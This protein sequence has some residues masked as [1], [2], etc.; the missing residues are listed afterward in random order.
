MFKNNT[1]AYCRET[2]RL[3][4]AT[5]PSAKRRAALAI[6]LN[7][8]AVMVTFAALVAFVY[9]RFWPDRASPLA[10]ALAYTVTQ[11]AIILA[12]LAWLSAAKFL[13]S[14]RTRRA[15]TVR[16]E[17]HELLADHATGIDRRRRLERLIAHHHRDVEGS[18]RDVLPLLSGSGRQ[19]IS[20]LANHLGL[21]RDWSRQARSRSAE[22]RFDGVV[23]LGLLTLEEVRET[24]L[25]ALGD[26]DPSV[27][28]E[29][30]RA[31]IDSGDTTVAARVFEAAIRSPLYSRA[32]LAGGLRGM[33]EILSHETIPTLLTSDD[34]RVVVATLEMVRAWGVTLEV[35]GWQSLLT[36]DEPRL[37]ALAFRVAPLLGNVR[38]I[39][40]AARVALSTENPLVRA[41]AAF[42]AGRL[43]ASDT[44]PQL[45]ACLGHSDLKVALSAAYALAELGAPGLRLLEVHSRSDDPRAAGVALEALERASIGRLM[46]PI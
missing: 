16:P 4:T 31:L 7:T 29:A 32:L 27:R 26:D 38:D 9:W 15:L 45:R 46:A 25:E 35:D 37:R 12:L 44:T 41:A 24:L 40:V 11:V 18:I 14:L 30:T 21:V 20:E 5:I 28:L 17:V 34:W 1:P 2:E 19:R 42:A 10:L 39:S 43:K 6:W 33:A 36:H 8:F 22:R 23:K 3:S 13:G